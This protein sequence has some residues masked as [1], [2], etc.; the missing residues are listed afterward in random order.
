MI[1][2]ML[3]LLSLDTVHQYGYNL[4]FIITPILWAVKAEYMANYGDSLRTINVASGSPNLA[5]FSLA[6]MH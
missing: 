4:Q 1:L 6:R 3:Q 2:L 5:I